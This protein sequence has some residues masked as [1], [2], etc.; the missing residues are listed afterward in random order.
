[1]GDMAQ[2]TV[3]RSKVDR[4]F[5]RAREQLM[6]ESFS[7]SARIGSATPKSV[8]APADFRPTGALPVK[9]ALQKEPEQPQH[10]HPS[11]QEISHQ[12]QPVREPDTQPV[13]TPVDE[14]DKQPPVGEPA[15]EPE[16]QPD[17]APIRGPQRRPFVETTPLAPV[18]KE[19][20]IAPPA[21]YAETEITGEHAHA[22]MTS[23]PPIVLAPRV[24]PDLQTK[25]ARAQEMKQ[26]VSSGTIS[27][28]AG[29]PTVVPKLQPRPAAPPPET[30]KPVVADATP[31]EIKKPVTG[32][33]V[34]AVAAAAPGIAL[35]QPKA[36]PPPESTKTA[37]TGAAAPL[38]WSEVATPSA[39]TVP[40]PKAEASAV[41]IPS[42]L[43]ESEAAKPE[44]SGKRAAIAATVLVLLAIAGYVSY[45]HRSA[46]ENF[47]VPGSSEHVIS[48]PSE[49][50]TTA[51]AKLPSPPPTATQPPEVQ[52]PQDVKEWVKAWAAALRSRDAQAQTSFYANPVDRYLLKSGV[53]KEQ[54]LRDKQAEIEKRQGSW[55]VDAENVVV[56][57]QTASDAVVR[58]TKHITQEAPPGIVREWHIRTQLKLKRINGKWKIT[59]EQPLA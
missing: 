17:K 29:M 3:V 49:A 53:G 5:Q 55:T 4:V 37:A 35:P 59:A 19:M 11:E 30:K 23:A 58:L 50:S 24:V 7:A 21:G 47:F 56:A 39:S 25:I 40:L 14:P 9:E 45:Q 54:L 16:R 36:A 10:P 15:P 48:A 28:T 46:V 51:A 27:P 1:M 22:P 6:A 13:G 34:P 26:S 2:D 42:F 31:P 12:K 33:A 38:N 18:A 43:P 57:S 44:R 8:A 20:T 32:T 41:W 52:E